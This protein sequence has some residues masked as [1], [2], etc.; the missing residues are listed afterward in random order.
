MID[1]LFKKGELLVS[2]N[3]VP[4]LYHSPKRPCIAVGF[5]NQ[6][7][8][9][10]SGSFRIRKPWVKKRWLRTASV[11]EEQP[12]GALEII[13]DDSVLMRME[14]T[15]TYSVTLTFQVVA[16]EWNFFW[17]RIP[18]E[19][20]EHMYGCGEQFTH[21]DMKGRRVPI[22]ISEPGVGRN[23]S[24]FSLA[25]MVK[26][27]HI[28]KW[29]NSYMAMPSWVSTTG[30]YGHVDTTL[31][32]IMDFRKTYET[33]LHVWGIP[34]SVTIGSTGSLKQS[35]G[36]LSTLLGKQPKLPEWTYNGMWLGIQGGREVT[37]HILEQALKAGV[38]VGALWCQDWEGIRMTSFGKQ[39]FW[40]WK[41]DETLYPDL[42]GY[43]KQL[44][45]KGIRFMGYV[46]T[47]LTPS[48]AMYQ[49]AREKGYLVQND[50]GNECHVY[51]PADPGALVDFTNP[52]AVSW[53][54][55]VIREH[56]IGI[57]MSGW[58]ADFGEYIPHNAKLHDGSS[59]MTYH[60]QYPVD[61]AKINYEVV[62]EAGREGDIA[63]FMR[64]GYAGSSRYCT[65]F[66]NGDQLVDWSREDGLPSAITA[67]LS[68]GA[69]G[70]GI[71]HSDIG[72]YTTAWY[73]KRSKE[74]LMRWAEYAAFTPIMRSHEGNRPK[75]NWQT[76]SDQETLKH[77]AR[78]TGV[79][80]ALKPYHQAVAQEYVETGVPPMRIPIMECPD[81]HELSRYPYQY[82]YGSDLFI[83]PV[84]KKGKREWDVML[85]Q[86]TWIHFWTGKPYEG[87]V[88]IPAPL[89]NPPVFFR[90]GSRW[91]EFFQEARIA[92]S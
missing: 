82:F 41:W 31:Y 50:E 61:W 10:S 65:A 7:V 20:G 68:L 85:P 70:V 25:A 39:L 89:G 59:G 91:Q 44:G 6:K 87:K 37:E 12:Q 22:W 45:E 90:K 9:S 76:Y 16:G 4:I 11:H 36:V 18:A 92:V 60:N 75:E 57:G 54:K 15:G 74:L 47:F 30:A 48:G 84:I 23:S 29:Y 34:D 24:L 43:I 21:L 88:C 72:G 78:M 35:A 67:S 27:K 5:G 38:R 79:Y 46:N 2:I 71:V 83:S 49:E 58:M 81:D 66:W 73:K 19:P 56:M 28:P 53:M 42:P 33:L 8:R 55:N 26:T 40:A 69:C 3:K 63:Y 62:R 32:S 80:C 64:A 17:L 1:Y 51:V 52:E 14:L 13:F 77:L 86:G